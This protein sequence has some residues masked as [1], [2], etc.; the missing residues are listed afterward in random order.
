M[1]G[2][3][4]DMFFITH[5]EKEEQNVGLASRSNAYEA[6]YVIQLAYYITLQGYKLEQI[7]IVTLYVGQVLMIRKV[8]KKYN[9]NVRITS[10]D[11]YQGEENDFIILSLVR[12]NAKFDIG[13]LKTFNRVCVAFSRA[14]VGFYVL[15]NIDCI[16]EG[17]KR[18]NEKY[19]DDDSDEES[20]KMRGVWSQ[21]QQKAKEKQ[22]IGP[23][24][25]L[26][27]Q[28]HGN[29]TEIKNYRDFSKV[30]EGGCSKPCCQRL[31][32]GHVCERQCH[33]YAHELI[34]C[35]K[36]CERTLPC[37][38]KCTKQC[39]QDCQPCPVVIT[40]TLPCGHLIQCKCGEDISKI[41]C[42]KPCTKIYAMDINVVYNAMKYV[43]IAY[44]QK[45]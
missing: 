26:K 19:S 8:A 13:F 20:N 18:A 25:R 3:E 6:N 27:C 5:S 21:I 33:N 42:K 44:V 29:I 14:K 17:E 4:S 16:V 12:S 31:K 40:K 30:Q 1:K 23:C 39:Y 43:H 41:K 15:G 45:W 24:L 22:I 9:F 37:G 36:K 28:K 11:N 7:T 2:F 38:H 35:V 32:C 10:V 34:Q